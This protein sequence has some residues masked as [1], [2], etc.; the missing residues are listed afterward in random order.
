MVVV[1]EF[2]EAE[3]VFV[4]HVAEPTRV[5]IESV[6]IDA[7]ILNPQS[8]DIT[9]LD[10][11]LKGG[12]VHYPGSGL[13]GD[14]TNMFLFGHSTNW[15]VVQNP[16]YQLFNDIELVREGDVIRVLSD[17]REYV[18]TVVSINMVNADEAWVELAEE[19]KLLISTCNTFGKKTDRF[20][21]EADF[22]T[23]YPIVDTS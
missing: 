7:T 12:V 15:E 18:Y 11:A 9:V 8:R 19:K 4:E 5:I 22:V 6:G 16:A 17:E 10:A 21:V 14:D 20:V 13:L 1:K 2:V 23:S 3:E